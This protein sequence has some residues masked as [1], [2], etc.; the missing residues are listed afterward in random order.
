MKAE[1]EGLVYKWYYRNR[2]AKKFV[3]TTT[4]KGA[5]YS[6]EMN[7]SRTGRQVYCVVEDMFGNVVTTKT[8]TL[9]MKARIAT[10]PKSVTVA[11]GKLAKVT[12]KAQGE[13]LKYTWYYKDRGSKKFVKTSSFTGSSYY[14]YMNSARN[15]RQVYCVVTDRFGNTVTAKTVSLNKK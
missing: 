9:S 8:V 2:G 13:G 11:S 5:T 10:Q 14:V 12:V 7:A 15:G 1:G 4:F 3:R 6:I